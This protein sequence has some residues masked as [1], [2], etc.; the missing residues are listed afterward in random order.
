V[1]FI[2]FPLFNVLIWT[3]RKTK[4]KMYVKNLG[5]S[6]T[7]SQGHTFETIA[8]PIADLKKVY[9][10]AGAEVLWIKLRN[11]FDIHVSRYVE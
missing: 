4:L 8:R 1:R 11:S 6:S 2:F 7:C 10:D 3:F 9:P 5:L